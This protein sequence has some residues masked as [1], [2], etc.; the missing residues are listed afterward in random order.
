MSAGDFC[1]LDP[2]YAMPGKRDRGE[3]GAGSFREADLERL[4]GLLQHLDARG[5]K[6]LLSYAD[7][8]GLREALTG[9]KFETLSVPRSVAGFAARR[10]CV[11]EV[12]VR[13]Y[14]PS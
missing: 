2:P 14:R 1:Y 10:K 11:P 12:L 3:Y 5:A 4:V 9:W 7:H 13:N 6:V 8:P